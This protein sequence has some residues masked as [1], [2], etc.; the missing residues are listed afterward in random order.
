[1]VLLCVDGELFCAE[2][3]M[4]VTGV[5]AMMMTGRVLLVC[6]LCV[7]WCGAG[8]VL[9]EGVDAVDGSAGEYLIAGRRPQLWWECAAA[10]S[11][12][13]GG[14]ANTSAVEKCVRQGMDGVRAF[15]DGRRRW[16][17]QQ[18]AVVAA[19]D[20]DDESGKGSDDQLKV[21]S[22]VDQRSQLEQIPVEGR[23]PN[24]SPEVTQTLETGRDPQVAGKLNVSPDDDPS[25]QTGSQRS[26]GSLPEDGKDTRNHQTP[27][28]LPPSQGPKSLQSTARSTLFPYTTLFRSSIHYTKLYAEMLQTKG[29]TKHEEGA[30]S[31]DLPES[32]PHLSP[33]STAPL[34]TSAESSGIAGSTL[35]NGVDNNPKSPAVAVTQ[36]D[37]EGDTGS[38]ALPASN[39]ELQKQEIPNAAISATTH[40]DGDDG[41]SRAASSAERP[42][43]NTRSTQTSGDASEIDRANNNNIN[44]DVA[45][46]DTTAEFETVS[47]GKDTEA[48]NNERYT[49]IPEKTTNKTGNTETT[50]DSDS[51]TAVSHTTSPLF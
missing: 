33:A 31:L 34:S 51:S 40:D 26:T 38:A 50:A 16:W 7:L 29:S 24:N 3:Y 48:D 49:K 27:P 37:I 45:R 47:G 25:K 19:G 18:F 17:R 8:G 21:S 10:V 11:R 15:V 1:L 9:A 2:G 46:N 4:Q 41:S 5:M 12:R 36:K 30:S 20:D 32:V 13:T 22:S 35:E 43:A 44:G 39:T 14:G 23:G 28:P 42:T 6:A